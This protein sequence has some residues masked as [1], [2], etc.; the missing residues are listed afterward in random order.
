MANLVMLHLLQVLGSPLQ[1]PGLLPALSF[2][3]GF[4]ESNVC[5][6]SA[7]LDWTPNRAVILAVHRYW[8]GKLYRQVGAPLNS[9]MY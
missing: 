3:Q 8:L 6:L 5:Q 2:G 7:N 4:T 9:E 1:M